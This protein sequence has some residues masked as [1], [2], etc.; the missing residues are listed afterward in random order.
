MAKI[1]NIN[2]VSKTD[3]VWLFEIDM[4]LLQQICSQ[5]YF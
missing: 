1:Q 2:V 4:L 3:I 5:K